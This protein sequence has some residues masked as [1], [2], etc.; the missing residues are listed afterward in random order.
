MDK[1]ALVIFGF[2]ALSVIWSAIAVSVSLDVRK[3]LESVMPTP[4]CEDYRIC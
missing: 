3:Q 2:L 1:S 4:V